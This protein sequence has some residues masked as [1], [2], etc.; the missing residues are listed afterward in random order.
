[1]HPAQDAVGVD[2]RLRPGK[3]VDGEALAVARSLA[4]L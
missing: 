1:M 3:K 4:W 2:L